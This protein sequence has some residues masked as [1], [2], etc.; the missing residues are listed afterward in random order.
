[1]RVGRAL[2]V[3]WAEW[4]EWLGTLTIN[5]LSG[6]GLLFYTTLA[7]QAP[8]EANDDEAQRLRRRIMD[9]LDALL[10][11]GVPAFLKSAILR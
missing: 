6:E 5:E 9:L 4:R 2:A 7:S 8:G 10:I 1:M 3:E 11:I